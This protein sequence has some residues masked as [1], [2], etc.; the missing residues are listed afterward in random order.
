MAAYANELWAMGSPLTR[1]MAPHSLKTCEVSLPLRSL[2]A[3]QLLGVVADVAAQRAERYL[4]LQ[5]ITKL[6]HPLSVVSV[7]GAR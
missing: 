1:M 6:T 4:P 2:R 3:Q 5:L 7:Q